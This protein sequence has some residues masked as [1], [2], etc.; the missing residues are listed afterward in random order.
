MYFAVASV[1]VPEFI[2][3]VITGSVVITGLIWI[4]ESIVAE[5]AL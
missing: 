5:A 4:G 3:T 2:V 1:A